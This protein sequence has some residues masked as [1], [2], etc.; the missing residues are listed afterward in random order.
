MPDGK[1]DVAR[2]EPGSKNEVVVPRRGPWRV[3]VVDDVED[4]RDLYATYF[5]HLGF[6]AEQACDGEEALAK[7]AESIPDVVIMD[8]SMPRLDGWEATRMI[9]ADPRT[10][11]VVVV[12]VTGNT[13]SANLEAAHAA[14]ADEVC[15]KPCIP[16]DLLAV[17]RRRLEARRRTR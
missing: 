3:L 11:Q 1:R 2:R 5:E 12:V 7:I 4:N 13:T 9:K 16:R 10:R 17:V 8:L 15:A 6:L 14:G